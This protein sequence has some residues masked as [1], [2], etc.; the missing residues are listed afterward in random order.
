LSYQIALEDLEGTYGE[1]EHLYRQHYSEM[2]ERLK[3]QGVEIP[4]YKPRLGEYFKS[5]KG[6]WLLTFIVRFSGVAVGYCNVYLTNDMH[7]GQ[8]IAQEDT[9]FI[10]KD[11]RNGIGKKLVACVLEELKR[12]DVKRLLVSAVTDLR[13]AK[14]WSRMGFKEVATQMAYV[15]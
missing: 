12:R 7:N 4:E 14:L 3:S 1:I 8:L 13:V 10:T 2:S 9:I 11:H 5:A 15:F 6:G